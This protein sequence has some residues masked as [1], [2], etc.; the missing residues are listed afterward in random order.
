MPVNKLSP[1]TSSE[2]TTP[3]TLTE[4]DS[5]SVSPV[6]SAKDLSAQDEPASVPSPCD[7]KPE[8]D[9]SGLLVE[10][11]EEMGTADSVDP[12]HPAVEPLPSQPE[13]SDDVDGTKCC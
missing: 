2:C 9:R 8:G 6:N 10:R 12:G 13:S 4:S 7:Q 1:N 3:E 5:K 11:S